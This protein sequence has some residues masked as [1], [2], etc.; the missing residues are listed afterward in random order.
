MATQLYAMQILN[1][2]LGKEFSSYSR[3]TIKKNTIIVFQFDE[4]REVKFVS[5]MKEKAALNG[6]SFHC[7]FG[8]ASLK[9]RSE[10]DLGF[11][12]VSSYPVSRVVQV[13]PSCSKGKV[14]VTS[15]NELS[16]IVRVRGAYKPKTRPPISWELLELGGAREKEKTL[17][18]LVCLLLHSLLHF[19]TAIY[20]RSYLW[21][22]RTSSRASYLIRPL[23]LGS[24]RIET[25]NSNGS[26][27]YSFWHASGRL[28]WNS[29]GKGTK[30]KRNLSIFS[31]SKNAQVRFQ[32]VADVSRSPQK[33]EIIIPVERPIGIFR[34]RDV[35]EHSD[36]SIDA[37]NLTDS[38]WFLAYK[39]DRIPPGTR[40]PHSLT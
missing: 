16:L 35:I 40:K 6:S 21:L 12:V 11:G 33:T 2:P 27:T 30:S 23:Q 13:M 9:V 20:Q 32:D 1:V 22:Q 4:N 38:L 31:T 39:S 37:Q 19:I 7:D 28:S 25:R 8:T 18:F 34:E 24:W 3:F 10:N 36:I 26:L 29:R 14:R 17:E 15:L 5:L